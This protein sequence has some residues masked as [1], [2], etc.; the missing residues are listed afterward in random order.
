MSIYEVYLYI[1][2]IVKL[3]VLYLFIRNKFYPTDK[4]AHRLLLAQNTFT[5]LMSL[6]IIYLFH[7]F[8][9]PILIDHETKLFLTG[10]AVLTL[11]DT[12]T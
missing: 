12:L 2:F 1:M 3:T 10:F 9:N 4:S 7:P 5:V 11:V 6:L 8:S